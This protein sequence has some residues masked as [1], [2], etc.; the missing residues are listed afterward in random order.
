MIPFQPG[1]HIRNA[2]LSAGAVYVG[3]EETPHSRTSV[4][5]W[6]SATFQGAG[7]SRRLELI[8]HL[9]APRGIQ[10]E[11]ICA[12]PVVSTQIFKLPFVA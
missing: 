1:H 10:K 6:R 4:I 8:K 7:K 2:C 12:R 11:N 9:E 3:L 5:D